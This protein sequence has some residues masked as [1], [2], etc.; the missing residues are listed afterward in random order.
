MPTN[1]QI[2]NKC[3]SIYESGKISEVYDY[4]NSLGLKYSYCKPCNAQTPTIGKAECALC[5]TY[6]EPTKA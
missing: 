4:C 6:K 5:S 3:L 1:L 2:R